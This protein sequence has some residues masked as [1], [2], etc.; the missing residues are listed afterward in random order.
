MQ[1]KAEVVGAG[2]AG[3]EAAWQLARRGIFVR[4]REMK[5]RKH[6]PAHVMDGFAELVCS[7]S[8]R[9]DRLSNAAGLL[10]AEMEEL[11]SLIMAAA[12][13]TAVRAGGAL[14][15]DRHAFSAYITAALR[16]EP[17]I[18][19]IE[20]EVEQIPP[21]PVILAPGPLCSEPL[22]EA[23]R[24]L[25]G[26]EH[27]A[28]FDAVA[29]IVS[30]ESV[31]MGKVFWGSRYG[32]GDDYLNCPMDAQAYYAF[33]AAL[34]DA[35]RVPVRD[36][37]PSHLF[38]GCMPIEALADAGEETMRFGPLKPKGIRHPQTDERYYAVVQLRKENESGSLLNL[39][40][41]Q[42]HLTFGEQKR[43]FSMIPGLGSAEF[44]RYGVMHKNTYLQAPALLDRTLRMKTAPDISFA[45]QIT[46]VEGYIESAATGLLAGV[47]LSG[48]LLGKELPFF[49]T[50]TALGALLGHVTNTASPDYQ[51]M[52]INYGL[53]KPL[54]ERIRNKQ[55]RCERLSIK[56]LEKVREIRKTSPLFV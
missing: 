9:S 43:V 29:P 7:N 21:G 51:P 26:K 19:I 45:G 35:A 5:P 30:A 46:G 1:P 31:D 2:L 32:R 37:E 55:E 20:E 54:H 56:A 42:T 13:K 4:L 47:F 15:V 10:K 41:F 8:L 50:D 44:Y 48:R 36:F 38:S 11:G 24:S 23:V 33:Y 14:A 17:H 25:T 49:D 22:Q 52:N 3:C 18:E 39:V 12:R 6:S 28:F 53:M 40:G 34:R 16:E 27:L